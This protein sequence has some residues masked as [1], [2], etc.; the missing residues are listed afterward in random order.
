MER[1]LHSSQN[2]EHLLKLTADTL[3]LINQS[4]VCE[5][6]YAQSDFWFLQEN[7]L[8]G[9][10]IFKMLP[11]HTLLKVYRSFQRVLK[12][13]K[14]VSKNY[15]LDLKDDT[16]YFK[17]ILQP[18][19]DGVL[20]QYRDITKRNNI[21]LQLERA[22][23]ELKEI[24][25]VA[26]IGQWQYDN[27]DNIVHF[28]GYTGIMCQQEALQTVSLDVYVNELVVSEDRPQVQTWLENNLKGA[29]PS[30]IGYRIKYKGSIYYLR[31]QTY[32]REEIGEGVFSFEGY[33]QNVTDI[34]RHRND[35]NVLTHAINNAKE[36]IYAA[37][38]EGTMVF[39][40]RTFRQTHNVPDEVDLCNLKLYNIVGDV[41]S[42]EEWVERYSKIKSGEF[43]EFRAYDP[44]KQNPDILAYEGTLYNVTTDEGISTYWSFAHDISERLRFESHIKCLNSIMDTVMENLPAGIVVKDIENEFRYLYRNSESY[45][46]E[47]ESSIKDAIGKNDFFFFPKEIAE[48]KLAED[49]SIVQSGQVV[50]RIEERKDKNGNVLILD[51]RK[52]KVDGKDFAPVIISIEWDITEMELMRRELE[53]A[54]EKAEK[55]D[56]LK[57]AFLANMS[58]EIRTPLNAIIGFSRIIS[59]CDDKDER[60]SYYEIIDANN[61]RLL[62]LINEI[63]DLSKIESGVMEFTY[64]RMQLYKLCQEI[65]YAHT[66]RQPEGVEL[67]FEPS[68]KLLSIESDKNR[69]FQVLS[70]LI[71][72]ASKFTTNGSIS[73]GYV[74]KGDKV[75][76]HVRDTGTGIAEN[77]L[78]T[79]FERF[80]K[81]DDNVQ[82]TGLGL[83]ICKSIIERL[84]GE[85]NVKS[86]LGVGTE[87][88]FWVPLCSNECNNND[89]ANNLPNN[90]VYSNDNAKFQEE[91]L[92]NKK[93]I[94]SSDKSKT[95]LVA[96]DIDNNYKL[97]KLM[98][99][100]RFNLIRATNGMDAVTMFDEYK[101]DLILMDL[102]MPQLNGIEATKIIRQSSEDVIVIAQSA[103]A[104]DENIKEAIDAGC[105]DFITKPI[106]KEALE[107]IITKYL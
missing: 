19:K 21:K 2:A 62:Q 33:V 32:L 1:T 81:L 17:C 31:L 42:L 11:K 87:F 61:E 15:R 58:H 35:I 102:N 41:Q 49:M 10:N 60:S 63:L 105:N 57:S 64:S 25:K 83:S 18:Y 20:C 99:N 101:P 5:D 46:R 103:Y 107:E 88:Y 78:R 9:K 39:A 79:V 104:F 66:F 100:D 84:G 85:I 92:Q 50:H 37:D 106:A 56:K 73:Y 40:N 45:N 30:S 53:I 75:H 96:E 55:S 94:E 54:K 74:Q 97:L 28:K 6:I 89:I 38:K 23:H 3:I 82:G 59:E 72:N 44:I 12:E 26:Q 93:A 43:V 90:E 71:G 91:D 95:V 52:L 67:I 80:V 14:K 13:K 98:F 7:V 36:S 34:Q 27:V 76:F 86:E 69:L 47:I 48:R 8:L 22:N 70:N 77:K 4:G 68:D 16:Y 24:Q 65:F 29:N 51:K